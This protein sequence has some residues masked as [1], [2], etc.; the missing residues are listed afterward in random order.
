MFFPPNPETGKGKRVLGGG[1]PA[2]GGGA[3]GTLY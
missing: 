1:W 3:A 2:K